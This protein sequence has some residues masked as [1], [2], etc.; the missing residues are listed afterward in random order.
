LVL[1]FSSDL[2]AKT[3]EDR[4]NYTITAPGRD[5]RFNDSRAEAIPIDS[6]IYD[7]ATKSVTLIPHVRLKLRRHYLLVVSGT[8]P[9]GVEDSSGNLLDGANTGRSGSDFETLVGPEN[10]AG[11]E[12]QLVLNDWP[13][14][15]SNK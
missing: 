15:F 7:P 6:A 4:G 3:A 14:V 8:A 12:R 9:S 5:G 13:S 2:N 11:P 1:V 10:L